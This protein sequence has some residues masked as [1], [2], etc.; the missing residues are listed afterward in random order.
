MTLEP[1]EVLRA[2]YLGYVYRTQIFKNSHDGE[3]FL[4][5]KYDDNLEAQ[6]LRSL[7]ESLLKRA[8]KLCIEGE[9]PLREGFWRRLGHKPT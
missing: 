9:E 2:D 1:S 8:L 7:R 3:G 6:G 4:G 5:K